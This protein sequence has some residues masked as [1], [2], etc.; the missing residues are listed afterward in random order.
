MKKDII[1]VGDKLAQKLSKKIDGEYLSVEYRKFFDGELKV[2]IPKIRKAKKGILL[3]DIKQ[4]HNINEF[5][6]N[7]LFLSQKLRE[8]CDEVVGIITYLPY[9]RQDKEFLKG[10]VVS[11]KV[12]AKYIEKNLDYFITIDSHEHRLK[13]DEIFS[14]KV[15]NESVFMDLGKEFLDFKKENTMVV[16]PDS[17][18]K[19]FVE[20]FC[21]Y[22]NFNSVVLPKNRNTKTGEVEIKIKNEKDF[23]NKDIII[24]DD[25]SASGGTILHLINLIKKLKVK[26]VS[27][28]L[29]H[30][31][32][33]GDVE[34]KFKSQKLKRIIT[35][36]TI[37][38]EFAK[39]DCVP[40]LIERLKS[41]LN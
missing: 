16:A 20:K 23:I 24:V 22:N 1:V 31:L 7:F 19:A 30:G 10:E 11:S 18:A 35:S 33:M 14:I 38:N 27:V 25:V 28:A 41:I 2:R 15:F 39:V 4:D 37:N 6:L 12:V 9:K 36:N 26:S 8:M 21:R 32:F 3:I 13:I 29:A 17:E 5:L 40:I 34:K